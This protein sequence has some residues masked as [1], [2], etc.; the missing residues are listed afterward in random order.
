MASIAHLRLRC[1]S[2]HRSFS[3]FQED[4]D[5]PYLIGRAYE[6]WMMVNESNNFKVRT[7]YCAYRLVLLTGFPLLFDVE[8]LRI[9]S[10]DLALA[11]LITPTIDTEKFKVG[12]VWSFSWH[13]LRRTGSVNMQSSGLVSDFSLQYLLKHATLPM[14]LYYGQNYSRLRL[15]E[16]ARTTYLK[17]MYE[18]VG[19]ELD[20]LADRRFVSPHG[21][22]RK[23]EVLRLITPRDARELAKAAKKGEVIAPREIILGYCVNREIC[24]WGGIDSIAHC[25]GGDSDSPCLH[26]LYDVKKIHI[27]KKLDGWLDQQLQE[28]PSGSP[29]RQSLEYQKRSAKNYLD[30][31]TTKS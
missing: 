25:G 14:A 2:A 11:R 6:P 24:P 23:T 10:E 21:E 13:Q 19:Q 9:T 7:Q 31:C 5:N 30:V 16:A 18:V 27:V 26:V 29:L 3:K 17:A 22:A 4:L 20:R 12:E 8:V 15:N 1:T 28:A